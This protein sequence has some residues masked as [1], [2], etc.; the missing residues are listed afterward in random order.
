[1]E[2]YLHASQA[3]LQYICEVDSSTRSGTGGVSGQDIRTAGAAGDANRG[4]LSARAD[5]LGNMLMALNQV[6][7]K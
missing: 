3:V 5:A 2:A 4:G 7:G 6:G 1:M